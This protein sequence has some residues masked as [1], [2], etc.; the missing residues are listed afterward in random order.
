MT[1]S[2]SRTKQS[3]PVSSKFFSLQAFTR[4]IRIDLKWREIQIDFF[5]CKHLDPPHEKWCALYYYG[6][7]FLRFS[8]RVK[9]WQCKSKRVYS[10]HLL[11]LNYVKIWS[12]QKIN[13]KTNQQWQ[14]HPKTNVLY[15]SF[16]DRFPIF[17]KD[18]KA[19]FWNNTYLLRV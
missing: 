9:I 8:F 7:F 3:A 18:K 1:A 12:W 16:K 6:S 11:F 14:Y 13:A 2:I 17:L 10:K 5:F 19:K 15:R 4:R